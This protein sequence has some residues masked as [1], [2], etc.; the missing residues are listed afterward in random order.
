LQQRRHPSYLNAHIIL[1]SHFNPVV[2]LSSL[3]DS[4]G[5]LRL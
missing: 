4:V 3:F 2:A 1:R 5:L